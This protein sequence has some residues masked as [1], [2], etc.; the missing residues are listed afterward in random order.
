MGVCNCSMLCCMLLYVHSSIAII[1]MG[2]RELV[3]MLNLSSWCLVM[4]EWLFFTVPLGCLR[5]VIVVFPDHTHLL[6]QEILCQSRLQ[7]VFVN[8]CF[9]VYTYKKEHKLISCILSPV[10]RHDYILLPLIMQTGD[11]P[12]HI[13]EAV[14]V[15]EEKPVRVYPAS[16]EN[17]A[18]S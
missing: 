12:S 11:E 13:P 15:L 4:V 10:L 2:K 8:A 18:T 7:T 1:L 14:Q 17:E 16:H 5:F 9:I 6:Y 3:A